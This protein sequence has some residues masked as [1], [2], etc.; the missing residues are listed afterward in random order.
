VPIAVLCNVIR[1]TLMAV[2]SDHLYF[3]AKRVAAGGETW[4]PGFVLALFEGDGTVE[5]LGAFRE[6]VLD[7]QSWLH[8]S[9]GFAMLGLA[10]GLMWL[11]LRA[12]DMFFVEEDGGA[13]TGGGEDG[14]KAAPSAAGERGASEAAP[15]P[16]DASTGVSGGPSGQGRSV[17][18]E[19]KGNERP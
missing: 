14:S 19:P 5:R 6:T 12:I 1:V 18:A 2:V 8:Q 16:P 15:V 3:Q 17:G 13:E 10:F 11:E 7:P 9:F 4:V